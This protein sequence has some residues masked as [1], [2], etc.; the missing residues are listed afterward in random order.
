MLQQLSGPNYVEA[1][2]INSEIKRQISSIN[3]LRIQTSVIL[4]NAS[5][6]LQML[7]VSHYY[8]ALQQQ[9][10]S[11]ALTSKHDSFSF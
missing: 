6:C 4:L 5:Y 8:D 1:Y 2:T 11:H 9:M 3:Y 10:N 7:N